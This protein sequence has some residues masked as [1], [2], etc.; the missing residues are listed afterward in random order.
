MTFLSAG[1]AVWRL[2]W[3]SATSLVTFQRAPRS[4]LSTLWASS[5]WVRLLLVKN[6]TRLHW[7]IRKFGQT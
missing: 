6:T 1:W 5:T 7:E 4:L 3:I 2:L